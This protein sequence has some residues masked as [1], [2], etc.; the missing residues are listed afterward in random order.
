VPARGRQKKIGDPRGEWVG[1]RTKRGWVR[2]KRKYFDIIFIEKRPITNKRD[3]TNLKKIGFGFLV[4]FFVKTFR[5]DVRC[6]LQNVFLCV[7]ELPSLRS[8]RKRDK[9]KKIPEKN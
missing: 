4:E 6:F 5:H 7:F 2:L 3:K 1:G 9:T 8:T